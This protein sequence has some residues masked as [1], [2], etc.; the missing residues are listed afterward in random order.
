MVLISQR[1]YA[2][3]QK[4]GVPLDL[5]QSRQG[6]LRHIPLFLVVL[7]GIQ[8]VVILIICIIVAAHLFSG[9]SVSTPPVHSAS[10]PDKVVP[11]TRSQNIHP[12][13]IE[14]GD[15]SIAVTTFFSPS[16]Q[17]DMDVLSI[18]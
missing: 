9:Q 14:I 5:Q 16:I 15:Y 12:A 17:D 13:L 8:A 18:G 7:C 1:S 3:Q 10:T 2:S 6:S 4:K 11:K